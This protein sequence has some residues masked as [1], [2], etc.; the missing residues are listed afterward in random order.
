MVECIASAAE[1]RA[2]IIFAGLAVA[3]AL[4]AALGGRLGNLSAVQVRGKAAVIGAFVLQ[5]VVITIAPLAFSEGVAS[6]LHLLSYGLAIAFLYANR[7]LPNAWIAAL[8]GACNLVAIAVNRGT[9]PAS[10]TALAAAGKPV[11][12]EGFVNSAPVEHAR[13]AFLGDVFSIPRS[14]PLANVFSIGDVILLIGAAAMLAG[15]CGCPRIAALDRALR[16]RAP[17]VPTSA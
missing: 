12:H 4:V 1:R 14:L 5:L 15:I 6:V 3:V 17:A 2:V 10:R 7:Q 11:V 9:M 13:L 16:R 8:G